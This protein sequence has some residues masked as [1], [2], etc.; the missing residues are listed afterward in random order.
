MICVTLHQ[1]NSDKIGV[2]ARQKT[3][4]ESGGAEDYWPPFLKQ[5]ISKTKECVIFN[6][7]IRWQA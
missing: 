2:S 7:D 1:E 6:Q 3:R 4:R 5:L